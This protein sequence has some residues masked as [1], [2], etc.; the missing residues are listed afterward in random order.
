[1]L[2]RLWQIVVHL[3]LVLPLAALSHPLHAA[4][5][6]SIFSGYR[7]DGS[8]CLPAVHDPFGPTGGPTLLRVIRFQHLGC[9]TMQ[10]T[11][12]CRTETKQS[13]RIEH[14]KRKI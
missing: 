14:D 8:I 6:I 1:M 11:L 10:T 2:S 9:I 4:P 3:F 12:R 7:T 13:Y 5:A